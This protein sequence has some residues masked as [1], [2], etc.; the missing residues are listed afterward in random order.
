MRT[1]LPPSLLGLAL[2][3]VSGSLACSKDCPN[4]PGGPA[5]LVVSPETVSVLPNRTTK[6]A[7]LVFDADTVLL[8]PLPTTWASSDP[9]VATVITPAGGTLDTVSILGKT[10]GSVT[11]TATAGGRTGVA[12]TLVVNTSALSAQ[13]VPIFKTSCALAYCHKS[14]PSAG[15]PPD[16]SS[17]NSAYAALVT[18]DT[19]TLVVPSDTTVG[20]L[21]T[22][23]KA[24]DSTRMP[25]AAAGAPAFAI[26][27]RGDY[28]LIALWIAEGAPKN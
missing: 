12:T 24:T 18:N 2:T 20:R 19:D 25:K 1:L 5:L 13:V 7:A 6:L 21:L 8:K 27:R 14:A 16:L 9:T 10:T 11:I 23:L 26:S 3:A 22:L 15:A 17:A 4:C 28:D